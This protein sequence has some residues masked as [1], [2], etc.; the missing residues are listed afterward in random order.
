VSQAL[1]RIHPQQSAS[2]ETRIAEDN[3]CL[4]DISVV[5]ANTIGTAC[6]P[7]LVIMLSVIFMYKPAPDDTLEKNQSRI[8]WSLF[9][10]LQF[11]A[12]MIISW[13]V[14]LTPNLL[15]LRP[16]ALQNA[17]FTA[18]QGIIVAFVF[19]RGADTET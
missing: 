17:I 2:E 14:V 8:A 1:E 12:V 15:D 3:L 9:T 18:V 16:D 6:G 5:V 11:L 19:P 7:L 13:S 10:L 4:K